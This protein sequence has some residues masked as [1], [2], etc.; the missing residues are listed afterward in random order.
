MENY[1]QYSPNNNAHSCFEQAIIFGRV[2]K[3]TKNLFTTSTV[4]KSHYLRLLHTVDS[5]SY[6]SPGC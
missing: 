3:G 2:I 4:Y 5:Y 1:E 6:R